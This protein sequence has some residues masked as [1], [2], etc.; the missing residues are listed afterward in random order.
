MG[1][2]PEATSKSGSALEPLDWHFLQCFGERTPGEEI[3]EGGPHKLIAGSAGCGPA[4]ACIFPGGESP[5]L[6]R[7]YVSGQTSRG[8]F[9][10]PDPL[11]WVSFQKTE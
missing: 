6:R 9:L 10:L 3:Q 7:L 1:E 8:S 5:V 2:R 4:P 11:D